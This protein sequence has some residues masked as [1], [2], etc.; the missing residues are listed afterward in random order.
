MSTV[1]EAAS[2]FGS[3]SDEGTDPFVSVVNSSSDPTQGS[4]PFSPPPT[5]STNTAY[6]P[7]PSSVQGKVVNSG[8]H[9]YKPVDDLFGGAPSDGADDP[10]SGGEA[11]SSDWLVSGD[12]NADASGTRG[13][14]SEYSNQ[15]NAGSSNAFDQTQGWPGYG[16][17]EQQQ[18][19]YQTYGTSECF[20]HPS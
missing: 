4:T 9:D 13:E 17:V 5:S 6:N 18:Q 16:Q 7:N 8:A 1:Q 10:F 12:V 20:S 14:Y 15:T 11:S 2:L 19:Y 3:G